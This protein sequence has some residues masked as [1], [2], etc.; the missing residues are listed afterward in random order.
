MPVQRRNECLFDPK[1]AFVRTPEAVRGCEGVRQRFQVP[2]QLDSATLHAPQSWLTACISGQMRPPGR[3]QCLQGRKAHR[4]LTES[5]E[6]Q[7][8]SQRRV[9]RDRDQSSLRVQRT[10]VPLND[11]RADDNVAC[12]SEYRPVFRATER[13]THNIVVYA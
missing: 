8:S 5:D 1:R 13:R 9:L 12:R 2:G 4:K 7:Q 10:G 6:Q 3:I 11:T